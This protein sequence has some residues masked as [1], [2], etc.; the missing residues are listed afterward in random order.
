LLCSFSTSYNWDPYW[1]PHNAFDGEDKTRWGNDPD[2]GFYIGYNFNV[3][4][5]VQCVTLDQDY[6][7]YVREAQLW[8]VCSIVVEIIC[9]LTHLFNLISGLGRVL[10]VLGNL[11]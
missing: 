5:T 10:K 4:K 2:T 11:S 7:E 6:D 1:A 3:A 8:Y 9:H